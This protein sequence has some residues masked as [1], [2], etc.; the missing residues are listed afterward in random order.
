MGFSEARQAE[1]APSSS[2]RDGETEA[3]PG[4]GCARATDHQ[5]CHA[6]SDLGSASGVGTGSILFFDFSTQVEM[7]QMIFFLFSV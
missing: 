6:H 4:K 3:L 2:C 1:K 7:E 5:G